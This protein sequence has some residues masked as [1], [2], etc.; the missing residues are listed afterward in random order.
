MSSASRWPPPSAAS[1]ACS[2]RRSRPSLFTIFFLTTHELRL[3]VIV[4]VAAA[5]GSAGAAADPALDAAVRAQRALRHRP[6]LA[7][8]P[9]ARSGPAVTRTT[10]PLPTSCPDCS[11]TPAGRRCWRS[12]AWSAGR[13]SA[14]WWAASPATRPRGTGPPGREALHAA[15][16]GA[17]AP[18]LLRLAIQGPLWLAAKGGLAR[19]GRA[20]A[21]LGVLKVAMGWPLQLATLAVMVWLLARDRTPVERT[22]LT[23]VGQVSPRGCRGASIRSSSSS[24]SA[25]TTNSSSS[26]DSMGCSSS[27]V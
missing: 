10:R 18:G 22:R 15:D 4:S 23:A 3:A 27:G 14:S 11:T 9:P 8:R 20:I 17:R 2:R 26:P 19:R 6:G 24:T 7:V 21:A 1:A 25:G 5:R 12:A 16:L 13:W